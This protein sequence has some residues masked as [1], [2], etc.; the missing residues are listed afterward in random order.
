VNPN[1]AIPGDLIFA[2]MNEGGVAGPGHVT[3]SLGGGKIIQAAHTGTVV[4]I[5]DLATSGLPVCGA[6]RVVPAIGQGNYTGGTYGTSGS[7]ASGV[8]DNTGS[9]SSSD[10]G[11]GGTLS[12]LSDPHTYYRAAQVIIGGIFVL[13]G[14]YHMFRAQIDAG[15]SR[16]TQIAMMAAK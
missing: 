2:Y 13:L 6:R 15:V 14:I 12:V 10:L 3:M 1:N 16:G 4:S 5:T 7:S 8:S 11:F 9:N